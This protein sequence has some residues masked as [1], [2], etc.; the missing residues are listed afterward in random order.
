[1]F[2]RSINL[3][4]KQKI[5]KASLFLLS[6]HCSA[7]NFGFI[8]QD[9]QIHLAATF[10]QPDHLGSKGQQAIPISHLPQDLIFLFPHT[11]PSHFLLIH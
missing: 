8:S 6:L 10:L 11:D 2:I 1:M 9:F 3:F 4:R 5:S 7:I